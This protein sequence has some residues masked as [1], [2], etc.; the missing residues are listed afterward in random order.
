[1]LYENL[2]RHFGEV[3]RKLAERK[4][5]HIEKGYI[6][7][8][9]IHMMISIS[10]EY[11]V[12]SVVGFIKGKNAIHLARCMESRSTITLDKASGHANSLYRQSAEMKP[13]VETTSATRKRK[14][15]V[16]TS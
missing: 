10:P 2:R 13:R 5:C 6:L 15:N 7:T 1:V 9:H 3:F 11:S 14:T 4:E 12:S 16:S 8:D